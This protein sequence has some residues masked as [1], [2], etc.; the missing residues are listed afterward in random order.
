MFVYGYFGIINL[1]GGMINCFVEDGDVIKLFVMNVV[2]DGIVSF[3]G[4][5][6]KFSYNFII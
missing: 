1:F 3:D 2:V 5:Y 6:D 4:N